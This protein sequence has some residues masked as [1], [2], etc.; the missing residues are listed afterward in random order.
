M[1]NFNQK[2]LSAMVSMLMTLT[3]CDVA[4]VHASDIEIYKLPDKSKLT[5]YMMLDTSGSMDAPYMMGQRDDNGYASGYTAC[6]LSSRSQYD[7]VVSGEISANGYTR[8]FCRKG[9]TQKYYYR[10]NKAQTSWWACGASGQT[11]NNVSINNCSSTTSRPN[12]EGYVRDTSLSNQNDYYYKYDSLTGKYY[13]RITIL[14]DALYEIATTSE[15]PETVKIGVGTYSYDGKGNVGY[16]R[17]K[18]DDWGEASTANTAGSQRNKLLTL[19][20]GMSGTG[21]TPTAQA[22]AEAA[23]ALLGT[24]SGGN[25]GISY[26]QDSST[27]SVSSTTYYKRPVDD[28]D[29]KCSGKGIYVLTDGLPSTATNASSMMQAALTKRGGSTT[30]YDSSFADFTD[31]TTNGWSQIGDFA[32][33]LMTGSMLTDFFAS[34]T[35]NNKHQIKTAVV[36][37]GSEFN[38]TGTDVKKTLTDPKSG[39]VRTY[40]NCSKIVGA[41]QK[42]TCYWGNKTK[43]SDGTTVPNGDTSTNQKGFGEGGFYSAASTSEVITSFTNFVDDM[44]PEFDP[45]AT[46]SPTIPVD[47]LNPIQLQP[48]GYYSTFTPKPQE[49]YQLWL[50]NLNKYHIFKGQLYNNSKDKP[51]INPTSGILNSD[52]YGIWGEDGMLG[53]LPLGTFINPSTNAQSSNR[54]VFT[55]RKVNESNL[56]LEDSSLQQ[57]NLETLFSADAT[58]AKFKNDPKKNYWLNALGYKVA[59]NTTGITIATLPTEEQRQLGAVMH[60][61]PVLLTQEGKIVVPTTGADKGKVTTTGRKD[62][63]LF[64]STQGMLHVVNVDDGKEVFAF[65]PHEMMENQAKGFLSEGSTTGGKDN[66]Y[67]GIDGAWTAFTQYVSKTDKTL[68]VKDSGRKDSDDKD[69]NQKGLQWVYGGLRMGGRSYYGLDL[70]N[71]TSPSLKFHIDPANSKVINSAG[72]AT[73]YSELGFMGQS[74]S[75]PTVTY[76]NWGGTRRLVMLVGGGYDSTGGTDGKGYENPAYE[77]TNKKGAGVYMFDAGNGELLWWASANVGTSTAETTDSGTI[78]T[79][80]DNLKYSVVSQINAI[81]RDGDGLSDTLYFGDLGGQAF[82]VDINNKATTKGSFAKRVVRL[83]ADHQTDGTSPRFY[84][85]PSFS[86]HKGV[87][88]LFGVVALS[89]GNRSSPL[90]GVHRINGIDVTTKTANDAVYVIYDNDV[91]R[92]DLYSIANTA[93]RTSPA[94]AGVSLTNATFTQLKAGIAQTTG[95]GATVAYNGGWKYQYSTKPGKYKGFNELY[96]LDGMLYVNVYHKDGTG[97]LGDCGSGVIGDTELYQFC[98]PTGKCSFYEDSDTK[99][100][101]VIQ[102]GGILGATLGQGFNNNSSD[103]GIVVKRPDGVDKLDCNS[104]ANK[105]K[106]ECQLYDNGAKLRQLRWYESR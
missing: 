34:T 69:L 25:G 71:I 47:A 100:N 3:V 67:Y 12:L 31:K 43:F 74:W 46:G 45:I 35:N 104:A 36:G 28:T 29:P 6:N 64:G 41:D 2:A 22:Y 87:D 42:N 7:A 78:G 80:N 95:T 24:T 53:Q 10:S 61:K 70:G 16:I 73:T 93:L 26:A 84:E 76:V 101:N 89:S 86:V 56:A 23:A 68:T 105:N 90:A 81:D 17:I 55:N 83:Y 32:R 102:G 44:K 88:G 62:Y 65:V 13:D 77:Q 14:K 40:Y 103:T 51:L 72:T 59:E 1:K 99:P 97:I 33:S 106:P 8:N 50:G 92:S 20:I 37:F 38:V 49:M 4:T 75:K 21:G 82:R 18:A 85:M 11:S 66:L 27:E 52:A 94:S 48:Y 54:V 91:A 60:S 79:N 57:V 39:K 96:A 98:L 30:R 63:L 19:I 58:K 9:G 15:I 5:I